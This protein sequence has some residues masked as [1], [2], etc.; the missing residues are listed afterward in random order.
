M[1]VNVTLSYQIDFVVCC[2]SDNEP[3][4]DT[5]VSTIEDAVVL[6]EE[7]RD[8]HTD[9]EWHIRMNVNNVY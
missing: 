4:R 3:F 9:K 6:L 8:T 1:R 2:D 5:H 7:A